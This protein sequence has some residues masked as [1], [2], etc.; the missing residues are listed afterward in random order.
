MGGKKSGE[1]AWGRREHA[2]Q[3]LTIPNTLQKG[4]I[5][6]PPSAHATVL[7]TN[8]ILWICGRP[9]R[10]SS[11]VQYLG[12]SAAIWAKAPGMDYR[13]AFVTSLR[14]SWLSYSSTIQVHLWWFEWVGKMLLWYLFRAP[15]IISYTTKIQKLSWVF[16]STRRCI[17]LL[18]VNANHIHM[19]HVAYLNALR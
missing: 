4:Y 18:M 7:L 15:T 10:Y 9:H 13:S 11:I 3:H 17:R 8:A 6:R 19:F 2:E 14:L 12:G 5:R 16:S 1:R